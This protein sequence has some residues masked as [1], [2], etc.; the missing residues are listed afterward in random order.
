ME[1][2]TYILNELK[3]LSPLIA[4]LDKVN[5]FTVPEGYFDRIYDT[6]L[7]GL[8]EEQGSTILPQNKY[9]EDVPDGYFDQLA[10]SIL[11][12][13][14]KAETA[15]EE[16]KHLSPV[17]YAI[18]NKNVFTVP[19]GYFKN[20]SSLILNKIKTVDAKEELA[21]LSPLLHRLQNKELFAVPN[22]YFDS[23]ADNII[24]KVQSGNARVVKMGSRNLIIKYAIAAMMTG[25]LALGVY[26]YFDAPGPGVD[27]ENNIA[28]LDSSIEKGKKMD[29]KQFNDALTNLTATD[30]AKYLE[31]NGDIADVAILRNNLEESNLP[32]EED[33]LLDEKTLEK[34]L[35]EI[36][37]TTLKN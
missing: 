4:G 26:K 30:I 31:N 2:T 6:V 3:L 25:T 20:I 17:L 33:Y 5:V 24:R 9:L 16:I 22:G 13:I 11:N 35:N 21:I 23:L 8:K 37:K 15:T 10:D 19:E 29:D 7:A 28:V 12:K 18:R 36:E 32:S 27:S 1:T 34:F 14:K